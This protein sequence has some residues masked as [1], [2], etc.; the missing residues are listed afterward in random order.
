[1]G[2][3]D[4]E[5]KRVRGHLKEVIL[6]TIVKFAEKEREESS[7]FIS[8]DGS[9]DNYAKKEIGRLSNFDDC[10]VSFFENNSNNIVETLENEDLIEAMKELSESEIDILTRLYLKKQD[11]YDIAEDL[12]TTVDTIQFKKFQIIEKLKEKFK[13]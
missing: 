8:I 11:E 1:M 13:V 10:S 12:N 9:S 6:N 5:D 4:V 2:Y 3:L 7:R